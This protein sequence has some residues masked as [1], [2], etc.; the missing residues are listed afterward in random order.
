MEEMYVKK[1]TVLLAVIILSGCMLQEDDEQVK[2]KLFNRDGDQVGKAKFSERKAGV[3]L[4]LEVERMS[5]G[6]QGIHIHEKASCEAPTFQSAGNHFNPR[7]KEHGLLHPD[8]AHA[9]DLKNIEIKDNG[10]VETEM[11]IA[12]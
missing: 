1:L 8:G 7:E 4:A 10:K 9:G 12:D 11:E 6:V 5:P 2:V 3:N